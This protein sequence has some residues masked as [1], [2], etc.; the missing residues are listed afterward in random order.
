ML[1]FPLVLCMEFSIILFHLGK[2]HR[3]KFNKYNHRELIVRRYYFKKKKKS[4][5]YNNSD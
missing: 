1:T 5:F 3:L 4:Y 2:G